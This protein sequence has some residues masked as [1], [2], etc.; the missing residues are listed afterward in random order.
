[1]EWY[2]SERLDTCMNSNFNKFWKLKKRKPQNFKVFFNYIFIIL[3]NLLWFSLLF[4]CILF[5]ENITILL[6]NSI[7]EVS[8]EKNTTKVISTFESNIT[9]E[10]SIKYYKFIIDLYKKIFCAWS[11]TLVSEESPLWSWPWAM[12]MWTTLLLTEPCLPMVLGLRIVNEFTK[13]IEGIT[14]GDG[15]GAVRNNNLS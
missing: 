15:I 11:C 4:F 9:H 8:K 13:K 12:V 3:D 1:M 7:T 5:L 2:Y 14:S 10:R 6:L